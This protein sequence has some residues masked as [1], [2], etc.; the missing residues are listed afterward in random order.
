[1]ESQACIQ[2]SKQKAAKITTKQMQEKAAHRK[3]SKKVKRN[4]QKWQETAR[5]G[6]K[7]QEPA[8]N[9]KKQEEMAREKHRKSCEQL[10]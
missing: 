8:K 7:R 2:T 4:C 6:K 10:P 5:N 1:M 3:Y 9:G